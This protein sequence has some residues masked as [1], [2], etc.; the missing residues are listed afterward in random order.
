[1]GGGIEHQDLGGILGAEP[2]GVGGEVLAIGAAIGVGVAA[3]GSARG[4]GAID[5]ALEPRDLQLLGFIC[6]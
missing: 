5:L 4:G 6:R 1:M 2:G 3:Q